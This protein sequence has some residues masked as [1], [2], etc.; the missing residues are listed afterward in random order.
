MN[1][2]TTEFRNAEAKVSTGE[3]LHIS[4]ATM[5]KSNTIL[6]QDATSFASGHSR[7]QLKWELT[8]QGLRQVWET[9][10]G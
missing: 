8:D 9:L 10:M 3:M 5:Q 2:T 6:P 7:P 4:R 1:V